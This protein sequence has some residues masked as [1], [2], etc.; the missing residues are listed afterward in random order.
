MFVLSLKL[1]TTLFL[2]SIGGVNGTFLLLARVLI[3]DQYVFDEVLGLLS[4]LA[5][6]S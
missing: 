2:T 3:F 1:V 4:L 6:R 5:R